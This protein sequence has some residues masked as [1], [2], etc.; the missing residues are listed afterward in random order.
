[1]WTKYFIYFQGLRVLKCHRTKV[2]IAWTISQNDPCRRLFL[3]SPPSS[4]ENF[5]NPICRG[6]GGGVWIFFWNN[7]LCIGWILKWTL[8]YLQ[9]CTNP[10]VSI[11]LV[12]V[13]KNTF[14]TTLFVTLH[15]ITLIIWHQVW[16][17]VGLLGNFMPENVNKS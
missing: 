17:N 2:R 8:N 16:R 1:M 13:Q 7:S 3:V 15:I 10:P 9:P 4:G 12:L 6:G 11:S 5:Q 14:Y